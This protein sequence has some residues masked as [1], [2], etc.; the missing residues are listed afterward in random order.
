MEAMSAAVHVMIFERRVKYEFFLRRMN[1]ELFEA[2]V[3]LKRLR[4]QEIAIIKTIRGLK[5]VLSAS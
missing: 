5:L 1:K 4:R 3:E 2:R